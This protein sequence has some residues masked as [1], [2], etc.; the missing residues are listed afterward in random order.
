VIIDL[1]VLGLLLF[2][3]VSGIYQGL[4]PQ[5]FRIGALVLIWLLVKPL[6]VVFSLLFWPLRIRGLT[7]FYLGVFVGA[8][9]VYAALSLLGRYLSDRFINTRTSRMELH[10]KLGGY[11]GF[12]KGL[13]VVVLVLFLLGALP[14]GYLTKKPA[15]GA[16][17]KG[18][19]AVTLANL[20]NPF[21]QLTFFDDLSAYQRLLGDPAAVERLKGQPAFQQLREQQAVKEALADPEVAGK[22]EELDYRYLL[23]E[24]KVARLLWDPEVRRLLLQLD[25]R[26]ALEAPPPPPAEV[27]PQGEA[28][29]A[30][31]APAG[32]S[33]LEPTREVLPAEGQ[34]KP[35]SP[36][37]QGQIPSRPESG[38]K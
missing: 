38:G 21:P 37:D 22:L 3:T 17:V 36:A 5:L 7:G 25:P 15:M 14:D 31:G 35:A 8:V 11:L 32:P 27:A 33:V 2:F 29:P 28:A 26:K 12:I 6:G 20:V 16:A 1:A 24:P 9:V 19:W 23:A 30:P 4:V 34:P 18:S 10:S 13:L